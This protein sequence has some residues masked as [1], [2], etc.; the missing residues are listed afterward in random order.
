MGEGDSALEEVITAVETVVERLDDLVMELLSEAVQRGE[1]TRPVRERQLTR[2][3]NA[4]ERGLH[5]LRQSLGEHA[6]DA[7]E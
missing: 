6:P 4:F 3:R 7:E 2:A 5:I 1:T